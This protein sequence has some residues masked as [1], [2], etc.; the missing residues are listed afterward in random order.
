LRNDT[1]DLLGGLAAIA[2]GAIAFFFIFGWWPLIPTNIAFLDHADRAMHTLGW[3]FYRD[4]PW[5]IPPGASPRLGIE[6]ANSIALV[7]GLPLFAVPLKLIRD[8]LPHPF[9]YWGYWW[10]L[11]CVLQALFSYLFGR[12]LG[13]RRLIALIAAGFAV[14]TPAFVFRLTLHMAL[15]GHWLILAA[16]WLYAKRTPPRLFAWPLLLVVTS[17]VHAYLLAMVLALWAA[18]LVQRLLLRRL[19]WRPLLGEVLLAFGATATTMW[20]VGLFYTGSLD[21]IGYG[22]YRLNLLWPFITYRDWSHIFPDLPHAEYDYE[23]ISFLGVGILAILALGILT[24]AVLKLRVLVTRRWVPLVLIVLI[25]TIFALSNQLGVL[26]IKALEIPTGGPIKFLGE[27]FRSTGRFN[28]PLLYIITIGAVVLLGTRPPLTWAVPVMVVCL[29]AQVADSEYGLRIFSNNDPKPA[30]HWNNDLSSPFW[31]RAEDA[32]YNRLRAI[33][34]VYWNNGWRTLEYA[35]YLH[36]WDV[37]AIYLGRVD[38]TAL[39]NLKAK[40]E[41]A[42][43]T[44]AFEPRTLYIIDVATALRIRSQLQPGDLLASIDR[45]IVFA[46]GAASLIEGLGIVNDLGMND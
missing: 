22:F 7:D 43:E 2:L 39:D 9:Q 30:D 18:S 26:D 12:E 16:L 31:Q 33:P 23:G 28:W 6:L 36:H 17:A 13:A 4:S 40:E 11:C 34:V 21:S 44:G 27:T 10:L 20:A 14:I 38:Q 29:A 41:Q 15:S 45:Q 32:G 19:G 5:G 42:I 37:D 24:G 25:L 1:R 35:A 46:R 3:M 8:W